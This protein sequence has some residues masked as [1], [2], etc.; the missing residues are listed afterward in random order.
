[1][2]KILVTGATGQ[3]GSS[4]IDRLL[5]KMTSSQISIITRKEE[6]QAA[7]QTNGFNAFLGSYDDV[8]SLEKAM[9]GVDTVLLISSGDQG[10]RMQEHKKCYKHSPKKWCE[11][12]CLYKQVFEQ[13][14]QF[15]KPIN[16]RTF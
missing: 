12:Y 7:F 9:Y 3:L 14:K 5:K 13:Q 8:N 2:N 1:M 15:G 4:V 11:T 16:G 6:K 10:D